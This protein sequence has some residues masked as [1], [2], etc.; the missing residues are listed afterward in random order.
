MNPVGRKSNMGK[1]FK[2]TSFKIAVLQNLLLL[3][4][5]ISIFYFPIDV[6]DML[7]MILGYIIY[8]GI[9]FSMMLH[10]YHTHRSFEFKNDRLRKIFDF[11]AV[12]SNRGS[13]VGWVYTHRS[14]HQKA[15]TKDDP[16]SPF[17]NKWK[18]FF[19]HIMRYDKKFNKFVVK[20]LLTVYHK[21]ID[22]YYFLILLINS[23][24]MISIGLE[25][26]LFFYVIPISLLHVMLLC[27]IY[28][29]HD[30]Y[31][32]HDDLSVNDNWFFG[33]LLFGEGWHSR[34]HSNPRDWN[35]DDGNNR[36]IISLIIRYLKA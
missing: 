36:E 28:F 9:G 15:D 32:V 35:F 1:V 17:F 25:F 16:H 2:A 19:P 27:F 4:G 29:G 6:Y 8:G 26:W 12:T 13:I 34:H 30:R 7:L 18:V 3:T 21:K 5:V 10:R 23:L 24:I 11:I 31:E 33:Y 14:H 22:D 20:D